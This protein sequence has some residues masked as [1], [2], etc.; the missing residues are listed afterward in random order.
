MIWGG[1]IAFGG[2]VA[3]DGFVVMEFSAVVKGDGFEVAGPAGN[4]LKQGAGGFGH[5]AVLEFSDVGVTGAALNEGEDAV[6]HA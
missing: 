3:L 5:C 4:D 2:E 1:E 6:A